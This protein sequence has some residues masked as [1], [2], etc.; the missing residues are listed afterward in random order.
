MI[1]NQP[2]R[3]VKTMVQPSYKNLIVIFAILAVILVIIIL[4]FALSQVT[5]S[6]TPAYQQERAGFAV[7]IVAKQAATDG[8]GS[9]PGEI[10]ETLVEGELESPASS[11]QVNDEK[12]G[13]IIT[14]INNYSQSQTLVATTR[15]L[16]PDQKLFRLV[17]G[18]TVPAGGQIAAE[19]LADGPG[20]EYESGS[21]KLTIPGL[22]PGLQDKIY[23]Q[24]QQLNRQSRT[25]YVVEQ[26]DIDTA[27]L[28]LTNQ[29]LQ[30]A[31]TLLSA[32]LPSNLTIGND[33][34]ITET[35]KYAVN[36]KPL[37][38]VES[39]TVKL[40]LGVKALIFDKAQLQRL[41]EENL[42]DV[43]KQSGSLVKIDPESFNYQV[44]L[45]DENEENLIAQIK[46][47]Y[48]L[49]VAMLNIDK[50][51]LKG[52]SQKEAEKYLL[53]SGTVTD[54]VINLPFWTKYLPNLVDHIN[55]KINNN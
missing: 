31:K 47:D 21:V 49:T 30:Q 5:I 29:L 24:A 25:K 33:N 44:T 45:L 14:I 46:V 34:L 13:G 15:F 17:K 4:Y 27:T 7:P 8:S 50:E 1:K 39:F 37:D 10:K 54:V 32:D 18:V 26:K 41:A 3:A 16:T 19:V 48:A 42:P 2:K 38:E 55:I 6:L 53:D 40:S 11:Y 43:Y 20:A 36:A 12:A 35:I 9:L 51:A 22:W 28:T 52:L 23:G